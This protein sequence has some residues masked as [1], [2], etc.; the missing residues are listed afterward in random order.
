M[1]SN[2]PP[3]LQIL[4]KYDSIETVVSVSADGCPANTGNTNGAIRLIEELLGRPVQWLICTLHQN[5]LIFRHL[6]IALGM[7]PH[8]KP[9]KM[10]HLS[11][12]I[13]GIFTTFCLATLFEHKLKVCKYFPKNIKILSYRWSDTRQSIIGTSVQKI[14]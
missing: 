10:S 8:S 4:K 7:F 3:L 13:C 12:S 1:Y 14:I 6:F 5:E 2:Q 11:F 9:F